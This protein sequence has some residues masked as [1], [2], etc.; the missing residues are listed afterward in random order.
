MSAELKANGRLSTTFIMS[1][2]RFIACK[3][4]PLFAQLQGSDLYATFLREG[5]KPN[6]RFHPH[7]TEDTLQEQG[8]A[9][10]I[11]R[12]RLLNSYFFPT[13]VPDAAL[14]ASFN[15]ALRANLN[16][17]EPWPNAWTFSLRLTRTG[18]VIVKM[19]WDVQDMALT[20]I[21]RIL[22]CLQGAIAP[23]TAASS[24]RVTQWQVA[25]D[26]VAAFTEDCNSA[27]VISPEQNGRFF[28]RIKPIHIALSKKHDPEPLPLHDRHL[29]FLFD[30]LTLNG[31]SLT[32]DEL[33]HSFAPQLFGLLQNTLLAENGRYT[34][35]PFKTE[36]VAELIQHDHA[37][38][39]HELCLLTAEAS[40]L[41]TPSLEPAT[42][43]FD[44]S[45]LIDHPD[46]YQHYWQSIARGIE[47]VVT[48]KSEV[49]TLER[50]TTG[51]LAQVADL[52][53]KVT[54]GNLS[55]T[56]T[57]TI[58]DTAQ[59]VGL[60]FHM[61]PQ[62]RDALVP[63][64][65]FRTTHAIQ[66]FDRCMALLGIHDI[67]RHIETNVQELNAFLGYYNGLQLQYDAKKT[68]RT[69][70]ILTIVFSMLTLLFSFVT[71]PSF[72]QDG[73][74]LTWFKPL[75]KHTEAVLNVPPA[76]DMLWFSILALAIILVSLVLVF[77][78]PR[79]YNLYRDR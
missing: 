78:L 12:R 33:R 3:H 79:L 43:H 35:P 47:F 49:Q 23:T 60:L 32:A 16:D 58:L 19:E 17:D 38:W 34:Y 56:D 57:Q 65:V 64:S 24:Q 71:I 66:I 5:L 55:R 73:V 10:S 20:D 28:N 7:P 77:I 51:Q 9:L 31:R 36:T 74:G 29:T 2:H 39:Q 59:N 40:L 44:G 1:L 45:H 26:I 53:A 11:F 27:F 8:H 6:G 54:D 25:M 30:Q 68:N 46:A 48:L 69:V 75:P 62:M 70:L 15:A 18:Q 61:L 50:L 37:N 13:Y 67:E 42:I 14:C 21:T 63:S 41:Y 52:A 4:R 76:I 72:F 22:L